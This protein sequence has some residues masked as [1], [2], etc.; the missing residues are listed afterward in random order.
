MSF[1][2]SQL[3]VCLECDHQCSAVGVGGW[4]VGDAVER[5]FECLIDCP[6]HF[7]PLDSR[8]TWA[9]SSVPTAAGPVGRR[10][11]TIL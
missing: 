1:Q 4:L 8:R 5:H 11:E 7:I 9:Q 10:K 2:R 6:T 3:P